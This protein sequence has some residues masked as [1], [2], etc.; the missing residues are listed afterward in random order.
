MVERAGGR[1]QG[2]I[3]STLDIAA[4]F[5]MTKWAVQ[6]WRRRFPD[7]PQ[8]VAIVR[9][10]VWLYSAREIRDWVRTRRKENPGFARRMKP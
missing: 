1:L 9:P 4:E 6:S 3:W 10:Y 8:P 7:F 2:R 5:G